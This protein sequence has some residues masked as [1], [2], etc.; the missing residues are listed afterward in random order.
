MEYNI[1]YSLYNAVANYNQL[2]MRVS[3]S[4][5]ERNKQIL[6]GSLKSGI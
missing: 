3:I 5:L 2:R 6:V 1:N 4:Q